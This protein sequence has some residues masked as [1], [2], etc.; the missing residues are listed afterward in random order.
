MYNLRLWHLLHF[1]YLF[2]HVGVAYAKRMRSVDWVNRPHSTMKQTQIIG[3]PFQLF[4]E[5]GSRNADQHASPV[6]G[7]AP[8]QH[9]RAIL[10]DHIVDMRPCGGHHRPGRQRGHD[11]RDLSIN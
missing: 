5:L 1:R 8:E 11:A 10:G 2:A 7:T 9:S 4:A 3:C 6:S